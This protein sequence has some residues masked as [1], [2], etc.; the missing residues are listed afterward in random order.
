MKIALGL[1]FFHFAIGFKQMNLSLINKH[2]GSVSTACGCI[3]LAVSLSFGL[4]EMKY[5]HEIAWLDVIGEGSVAAFT[6]LWIFFLL[7][8]RPP[9]KVTTFLVLG[10]SCFMFSALLD[11]FDEFSEYHEFASRLGLF[12]SIPAAFGMLLMSYALYQWH[13]EQLVLNKQLRRREATYREHEQVDRVTQLYS[14]DYMRDRLDNQLTE[15]DRDF[16]VIMLDIDD[17]DRFNRDFGHE[18]GDRLLREISELILMNL[19]P[20]DLACRYA[21]D[22]F[23]LHLPDT[24]TLTANELAEQIKHSV[25]SLAFKANQNSAPVYNTLSYAVESVLSGDGVE[26]ILRRVNQRLELKKF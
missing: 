12:E 16:S 24:N 23:V 8:S 14:A 22:R 25:N 5:W 26:S 19:R 17:F 2:Q 3:C 15:A 10:L 20:R 9:G 6:M 21:G 7:V 4:G 1:E 13:Q 11:V 18:Q